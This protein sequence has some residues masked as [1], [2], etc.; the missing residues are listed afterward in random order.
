MPEPAKKTA[1]KKTSPTHPDSVE[2]VSTWDRLAADFPADWIE[3]LPKTLKARDDDKGTCREGSRYSADGH[4]CGKYHARAVH[5]DYVGHAGITMRLND[6]LGPGGWDF[7]PMAHTPEGLPILTQSAFWG[8]LTVTVDGETVTK[9]ELATNFNGA[10]E[11]LGDCLRRCAMRFGIGTYLWSKSDQ[12]LERAK[13][14]E[15]EPAEAEHPGQQ[16]AGDAPSPQEQQ[17]LGNGEPVHV[18]QVRGLLTS[19]TEEERAVI[20]PWW[21]KAVQEG[22]LPPRTHL[23]VL[24]PAQ[25][26]WV[27][28]TV[29]KARDRATMERAR[30]EA[31]RAAQQDQPLPDP[32]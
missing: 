23:H 2:P 32:H 31:E 19:L 13:A 27:Q 8:K 3:K 16:D 12:A 17:T 1:A 7:Q 22:H 5:L 9:W 18:V 26:S 30:Q 4:Y 25:A 11:A 15:A 28:E 14:A 24:S 21:A 6:V 20:G 29:E 10:Q